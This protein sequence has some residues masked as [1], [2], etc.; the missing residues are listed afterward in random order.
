MSKNGR[1]DRACHEADRVDGKCLKRPDPG[2][3]VWEKQ[4]CEDEARDNAVKEK[5]VPFD[6]SPNGGSN[7]G[8]AKL[9]LMFGWRERRDVVIECCHERFL[10]N[11]P[12]EARSE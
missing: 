12:L 3:R 8:S 4:L 10:R 7:D 6:R 11:N 9:N 2:V 5:I 1:A